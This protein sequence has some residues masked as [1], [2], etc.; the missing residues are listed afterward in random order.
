MV[1]SEKRLTE[2]DDI[3]AKTSATVTVL[4]SLIVDFRVRL[5]RP[6]QNGETLAVLESGVF[7]GGKGLNQAI[8][9]RRLGGRSHLMGRLGDDLFGKF[10]LDALRKE[11]MAID[12]ITIDPEIPTGTAIPVSEGQGSERQ[13][14][15]HVPGANQTLVAADVSQALAAKSKEGYL[16]LQGEVNRE[17][18]LVAALF[19]KEHGIAVILDPAPTH[20]MSD[21]LVLLADY[22]TPNQV[23]LAQLTHSEVARDLDQA[24]GQADMLFSRESHLTA[25]VATLGPWGAYV[26]S[27]QGH[28]HI[29]APPVTAEDPTAAGDVF[30]A[31]FA[32]T[33]AQGGSI[34]DA[35]ERGV[36]AGTYACQI[37][38]ALPSIPRTTDLGW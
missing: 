19:A 9:V 31:A 24:I 27:R 29:A 2:E 22:L 11:K 10:L 18:N 38:G 21:D 26:A 1:G 8:G 5:P 20:A 34:R 33:L 32:V 3:L 25:V 23:E 36:E 28:F 17:A 4:G 15:L 13:Y 6:P 16:M 7:A 30:N 14:I 35:A 12:G 37:K